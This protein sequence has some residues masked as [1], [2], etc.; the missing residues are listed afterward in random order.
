LDGFIQVDD[1]GPITAVGPLAARPSLARSVRR[2]GGAPWATSWLDGV[3]L[4]QWIGPTLPAGWEAP[5]IQWG[6]HTAN[7]KPRNEVVSVALRK[8]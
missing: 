5:W 2:T 1:G 4:A 7:S 3:Q 6:F 8:N